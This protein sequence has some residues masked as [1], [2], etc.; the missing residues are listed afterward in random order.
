MRH[1]HIF[2]NEPWQGI[3]VDSEVM[4]AQPYDWERDLDMA[5]T[6]LGAKESLRARFLGLAGSKGQTLFEPLQVVP[7]SKRLK[8]V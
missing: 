8:S 6:A 7:S 2:T 4:S 1:V 5:L 3:H